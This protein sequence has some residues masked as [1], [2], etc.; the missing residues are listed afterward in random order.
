MLVPKFFFHLL[1]YTKI[2]KNITLGLQF[3]LV[4][5]SV[6]IFLIFEI[7]IQEIIYFYKEINFKSFYFFKVKIPNLVIFNTII[8]SFYNLLRICSWV[9]LKY[10]ILK[11]TKFFYVRQVYIFKKFFH[12]IFE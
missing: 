8:V 1:Y 5:N 2:K 9:R 6:Y 11:K 12:L 4:Y 3:L 7:L 10:N